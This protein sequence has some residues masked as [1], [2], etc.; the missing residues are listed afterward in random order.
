MVIDSLVATLSKELSQSILMSFPRLRES[1]GINN[2][3]R[4]SFKTM[5]TEVGL[6]I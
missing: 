3:N 2:Y 6:L 4:N 5:S 1:A